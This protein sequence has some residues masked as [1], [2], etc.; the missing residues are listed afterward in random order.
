MELMPIPQKSTVKDLIRRYSSSPIDGR[1]KSPRLWRFRMASA[2]IEYPIHQREVAF[3][4]TFNRHS[5]P[6]VTKSESKNALEFD[7]TRQSVAKEEEAEASSKHTPTAIKTLVYY[8]NS[9]ALGSLLIVHREA[10]DSKLQGFTWNTFGSL[11][12]AASA[13][14]QPVEYQATYWTCTASIGSRQRDPTFGESSIIKAQNNQKMQLFYAQVGCASHNVEIA[15]QVVD[16]LVQTTSKPMPNMASELEG[17]NKRMGHIIPRLPCMDLALRLLSTGL[18]NDYH[19]SFLVHGQ[20]PNIGTLGQ[21]LSKPSSI[22]SK[23][24]SCM[25]GKAWKIGHCWILTRKERACVLI[26]LATL[27]Q[28]VSIQTGLKRNSLADGCYK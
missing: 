21:V 19:H 22:Y 27:H 28:K 4:E 15:H 12:G 20:E 14:L 1:P 23:L 13:K 17:I 26:S 16:A 9:G 7:S 11:A 18:T 8:S 2:V 5:V 24:M 25:I 10:G 3:D 6:R